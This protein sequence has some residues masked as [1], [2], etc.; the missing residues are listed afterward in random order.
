M[1][2]SDF[3]GNREACDGEAPA[4]TAGREF[5]EETLGIFGGVSV[6]PASVAA[7]STTMAATLR[8]DN[9]DN[10]DNNTRRGA[11]RAAAGDAAASTTR[12]VK[13]PTRT[14]HY[15]MYLAEVAYVD[16]LMFHLAAE[17][18]DRTK[19]VAC[20]EKRSFVWV[21]IRALLAAVHQREVRAE[22]VVRA[23]RRVGGGGGE[24]GIG[25]GWIGQ[26]GGEGDT[27]EAAPPK[28][29][30]VGGRSNGGD[31]GYGGDARGNA[32]SDGSEG[33]KGGRPPVGY[34]GDGRGS[35]GRVVT[36]RTER[37]G[38]RRGRLLRLQP[39]FV[40]SL[41]LAV[42]VGAVDHLLRPPPLPP[43]STL[44][45]SIPPLGNVL[46]ASR[47]AH[48]GDIEYHHGGYRDHLHHPAPECDCDDAGKSQQ[49]SSAAEAMQQLALPRGLNHN[50][51]LYHVALLRARGGFEDSTTTIASITDLDRDGAAKLSPTFGVA[52]SSS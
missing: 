34:G 36:L 16:A 7:S 50:H 37:R 12:V 15:V 51:M 47:T 20:A 1:Y 41:R 22:R 6:D 48:P 18:N 35:E 9:D 26:I 33:V 38:P 3:G 11:A 10:N 23:T 43:P 13:V 31:G 30:D 24:G 21:P 8:D 52:A 46:L 19:T 5:A 28:A 32:A 40:A 17:Q 25:G 42:A 44:T 2:W 14:G 49:G 4:V 29:D 45:S 39:A 27:L